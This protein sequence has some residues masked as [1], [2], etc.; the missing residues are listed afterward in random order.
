MTKNRT[1]K[2]FVARLSHVLD[3]NGEV[4]D[5]APIMAE[6]TSEIRG[7]SAYATYTVRND[8]KLAADLS[9]VAVSQ[10]AVAG[11][12]AGVTMPDFLVTGKSGRSRKEFL[13]QHRVVTSFRSWQERIAVVNG[14]SSKYVSQGWKRTVNASAPTY[15]EDTVNLR[16][17]YQ[18]HPD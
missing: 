16:T 15:G 14:E 7:I 8:T 12:R 2:A 13:V 5:S 6:L 17:A 18:Q 3:L 1:Y 10:P 4:L 11:R 9:Q